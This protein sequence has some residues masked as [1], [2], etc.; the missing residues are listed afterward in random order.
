MSMLHKL[1]NGILIKW[2]FGLA[3]LVKQNTSKRVLIVR[4]LMNVLDSFFQLLTSIILSFY[5]SLST[6]HIMFSNQGA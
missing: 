5:V 4:I 6:Q 2:K 1:N 3:S